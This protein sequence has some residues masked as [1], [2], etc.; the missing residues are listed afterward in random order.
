MKPVLLTFIVSIGLLAGCASVSMMGGEKVRYQSG[1]YDFNVYLSAD[2]STAEAHRIGL[3][4]P[5]PSRQDVMAH[6]IRAMA[7]VSGCAVDLPSLT[8]DQA[9]VKADLNCP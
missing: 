1:G 2:R 6:A 4:I 8:G 5:P 9:I 7:S 3:M